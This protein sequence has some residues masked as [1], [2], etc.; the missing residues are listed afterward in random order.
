MHTILC[1]LL[2]SNMTKSLFLR[3]KGSVPLLFHLLRITKHDALRTNKTELV[4]RAHLH[5]DIRAPGHKCRGMFRGGYFALIS[6]HALSETGQSAGG[7]RG[8]Y[9]CAPKWPTIQASFR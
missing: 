4:A 3:T 8:S 1:G 7:I 6:F 9:S 5:Q 2:R